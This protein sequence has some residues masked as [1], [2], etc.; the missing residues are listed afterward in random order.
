MP[1]HIVSAYRGVEFAVEGDKQDMVETLAAI[2]YLHT[3]LEAEEKKANGGTSAKSKPKATGKTRKAATAEK[4]PAVDSDNDSS[5][6]AV[7]PAE[8]AEKEQPDTKAATESAKATVSEESAGEPDASLDAVV[9]QTESG[10]T[11]ENEAPAGEKPE[12][13]LTDVR[14]ALREYAQKHGASK[15]AALVKKYGAQKLSELAEEHWADLLAE[16]NAEL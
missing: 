4:E 10:S 16:A 2:D 13:S 6:K 14:A 3:R 8:A 15:G 12:V 9:E 11:E 7:G 1:M 5:D